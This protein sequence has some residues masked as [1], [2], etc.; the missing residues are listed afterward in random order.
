V[1]ES[2]RIR[3][4]FRT[5][6]TLLLFE[7]GA[8]F[9]HGTGVQNELERYVAK[10]GVRDRDAF[11]RWLLEKDWQSLTP[12]E[13]YFFVHLC[14]RIVRIDARGGMKVCEFSKV[15]GHGTRVRKEAASR[16]DRRART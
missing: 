3:R 13:V 6:K 16:R 14:E 9:A 10:N 12:N 7:G 1:I 15:E 4:R 2:A 5:L 8:S 11:V